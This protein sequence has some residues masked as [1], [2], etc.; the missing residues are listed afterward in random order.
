MGCTKSFHVVCKRRFKLAFPSQYLTTK[1]KATLI[2]GIASSCPG[3]E[4]VCS[5]S[6]KYLQQ[7]VRCLNVVSQ[8]S[9]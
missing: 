6:S 9:I 8:A 3:A 2:F 4:V 5:R 1:V 7:E